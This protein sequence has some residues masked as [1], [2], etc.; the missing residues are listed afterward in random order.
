MKSNPMGRRTINRCY[1]VAYN[2][3]SISP[4]Q[5]YLLSQRKDIFLLQKMQAQ[6]YD[7]IMK[8]ERAQPQY[9][10][11]GYYGLGFPK[12]VRVRGRHIPYL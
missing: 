6:F 2:I 5:S 7:N 1:N 12:C 9:Y 4:K 8:T 10:R 3:K 11:V